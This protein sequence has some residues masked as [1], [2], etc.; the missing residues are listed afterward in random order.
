MVQTRYPSALKT[1]K[2]QPTHPRHALRHLHP[3]S[4]PH[5]RVGNHGRA[6]RRRSW[7]SWSCGSRG[8]A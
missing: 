2:H 5:L 7:K 1:S 8:P 4:T 6:C 3:C